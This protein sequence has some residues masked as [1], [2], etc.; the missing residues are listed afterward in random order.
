MSLL[1]EGHSCVVCSRP[2]ALSCG[3][4]NRAWY[5]ST[6]H[7][8]QDWPVHGE[9]CGAPTP[10]SDEE[11]RV[12]TLHAVRPEFSSV[13]GIVLMH[14]DP[15]VDI[16][17]VQCRADPGAHEALAPKPLLRRWFTDSPP[18]PMILNLGLGGQVLRAPMQIW[19]CPLSLQRG[20]PVNL[21]TEHITA[22]KA[23]KAWCGPV[24]VLKFNGHR[25]R[26]YMDATVQDV[27][28]LTAYFLEYAL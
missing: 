10:P 6:D 16:V 3:Q 21:A 22:G 19:Y 8:R 18:E 5:C 15:H 24:V 13:M 2:T 25:C 12:I 20:A 23:E 4:C 7:L 17:P 14:T 26:R 1:F 27:N 11:F 28:L 9:T